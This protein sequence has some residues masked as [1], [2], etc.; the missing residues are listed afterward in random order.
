VWGNRAPLYLDLTPWGWVHLG[1]G[2]VLVLTGLGLLSGNIL[3]RTIAVFVAGLSIMA[4]FL[5]MPAYPVWSLTI[6]TIDVFV[7][8][9]LTAHG[10]DLA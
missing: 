3:A 7:I 9:A 4:N 2:V 8:F 5:F 1:I 10:R 6:I